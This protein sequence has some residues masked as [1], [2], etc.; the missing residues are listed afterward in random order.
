MST[1]SFSSGKKNRSDTLVPFVLIVALRKKEICCKTQCQYQYVM[2]ITHECT[3]WYVRVR[4]TCP[5]VC[6]EPWVECRR[7]SYVLPSH[8]VLLVVERALACR[9][10]S[11]LFFFSGVVVL[12]F[13][14]LC[15]FSAPPS[16]TIIWRW[17]AGSAF[18]GCVVAR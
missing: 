6:Y 17:R 14:V 10:V 8:C 15:F 12:V 9:C 4:A 2:I 5:T 13:F 7:F 11:S 1:G 16:F 3:T 18:D